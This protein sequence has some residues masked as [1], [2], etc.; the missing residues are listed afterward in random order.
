[1]RKAAYL[2]LAAAFAISL[3]SLAPHG[4][5]SKPVVVKGTVSVEAVEMACVH[6]D[7]QFTNGTGKG[8]YGCVTANASISCNSKGK[9]TGTVPDRATVGAS[10]LKGLLGGGAMANA[11]SDSRF[12]DT[13]PKPVTPAPG[14]ASANLN[15]PGGAL[16]ASVAYHR[17]LM[18]Q[19][20]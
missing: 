2:S 13:T 3:V 20:N 6:M 12:A 19:H 15:K 17:P 10:G 14:G 11:R 18:G 1:M 5:F 4:A 16:A 8:G 7:G 9:C